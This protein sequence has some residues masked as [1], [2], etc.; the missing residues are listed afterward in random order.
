MGYLAIEFLMSYAAFFAVF[1]SSFKTLIEETDRLSCLLYVRRTDHWVGVRAMTN[2]QNQNRP[3][4]MRAWLGKL[5][6]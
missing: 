2:S 3:T 6:A 4:R 5:F 1:V